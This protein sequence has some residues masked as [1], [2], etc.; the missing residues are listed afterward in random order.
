[1]NGIIRLLD[2]QFTKVNIES[3]SFDKGITDD[4]KST[5]SYIPVFEGSDNSFIIKFEIT[6]KNE[7]FT[8]E[9]QSAS[10]F[11]TTESITEEFK[12]SNFPKINAPAIAYPYVRAFISNIMLSSGY[13]PL[14]LPSL[15]FVAIS[16]KK[17]I[18][19]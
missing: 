18:E 1:M 14:V 7:L 16:N 8:L 10:H 19:Q 9:V 11:E 13:N 4:L 2:T 5:L 12:N 17:Q 15:N 6:L 3:K